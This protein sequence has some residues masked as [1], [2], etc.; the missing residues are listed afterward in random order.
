MSKGFKLSL[1]IV[2]LWCF[3]FQLPIFGQADSS[4]VKLLEMSLEDIL[5]LEIITASKTL[6]SPS[7]VT[8]KVDIVPEQEFN[9]IISN[10]RN[11]AELIQYL[12][13]ASVKVLSRNDANWG[14]YGGI[15]P[16]YNT[17]MVNG[18][19]VD[20]FIDPMSIDIMGVQHIEI[21]RGPASVL[22][23][24]YLSQDF[25]GNQS[26]LAGTVNLILKDRI[27]KP[28]TKLSVAY[29]SYN[30]LSGQVYHEN[31]FNR[32]H[33]FGGVSYEKSDY[34]N[35]GSSDSW[36]NMLKNPEYQ[37]A[38]AF[39]GATLFIDKAEKH[40]ITFFGNQ[41]FH[42]GDIG[43]VTRE[44]DN[45]YSLMNLSYNGPLTNNIELAFKTGLR[46][47]N[48]EWQ[49]DIFDTL[50]A[51]YK[52]SETSGVEQMIIPIDLSLT[53]NHFKNSNLT[54]GID[55]QN[56][57]YLTWGQAV[58]NEKETGN[59]ALASQMGVYLQE[60][61]QL[62]KFTLRGGGR[63]NLIN[64]DIS[65]FGGESPGNE[66]Q[67]WNVLLWS[68]GAKYRITNKITLFAN[69]GNS[70]MS[71]SLKSI[72]GTLNSNDIYVPGKNGQLPNPDLKPENGISVDLGIDW[73]LA[74]NVFTCLRFFSTT[75]KDAIIDNVISQNPSQ[76]MSVN[77]NGKTLGNGFEI[78]FRQQIKDKISYFANMTFTDS[79]IRDPDNE[80]QNGTE[81]PFVPKWMGNLGA[82]IYL[83]YEFELSPMVHFGG[84]IYD[85]SS[86]STR[87]AFDSKEVVNLMVSNI[88][89]LNEDKSL[90][91]YLKLYNITNNKY[92]M[93]WQFLDPGFNIT[94]GTRILL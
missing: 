24:N 69:S 86:K 80:D 3:I 76:T 93:P 25:A 89:K 82:T 51:E 71:P 40:K 62:G 79:E 19:P 57:S 39:I 15:G 53:Y 33:V 21:Q 92:K 48:R 78:S 20:G 43:R 28:I 58:N 47:Y 6:R 64:Y 87:H 4:K 1:S 42:W 32:L 12:P 44:Y 13:G 29:G 36:L 70:F 54:I 38:K 37:K 7:D 49:E 74:H 67:N 63:F 81:V 59:D 65:K 91:L 73:E 85:N 9:Q 83:P 75:I 35:Y 56:A 2:V 94:F 52:L 10:N 45:N 23:P 8:Q 88:I 61:L 17:Y 18:L 77:T 16:K 27:S 41:T 26:P 14:A 46:W 66:N 22:Y 55:Y 72:G 34:T 60:E 84:V 30:T 90:T 50:S 31:S 11:I 68:A 5:K